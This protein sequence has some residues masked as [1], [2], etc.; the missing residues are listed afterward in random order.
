MKQ[1]KLLSL[2]LL[3]ILFILATACSPAETAEAEGVEHGEDDGHHNDEMD[4]VHAEAPA[5]FAALTN[6][7]G[8]DHEAIEAGEEIFQANCAACHGPEGQGD[9]PAAETLEPKPA[10]L[11]DG[12]MMDML[13]DGYLFWRVS[14][15]GQMEPFHSAMPAWETG[16]SEEQRWQVISYVRT[17]ADEADDNEEHGHAEDDHTEGDGHV[18]DDHAEDDHHM[19]EDTHTEEDKHT[20]DT[21]MEDDHHE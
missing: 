7:F 11:A 15:G 3:S 4:H 19:H 17:L 14:K 16:L 20:E 18:K 13:S 5:E 6:P 12:M 9:G 1:L 8:G 10:T 21:H 2:L